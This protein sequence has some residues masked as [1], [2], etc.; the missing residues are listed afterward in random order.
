MREE[1]AGSGGGPATGE[2]E[3]AAEPAHGAHERGI[4]PAGRSHTELHQYLR[5]EKALPRESDDLF[6]KIHVS[7]PFDR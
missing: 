7:I 3:A 5:A 4:L 2:A 6:K 1:A